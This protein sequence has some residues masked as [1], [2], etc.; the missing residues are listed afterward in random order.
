MIEKIQTPDNKIW[1]KLDHNDKNIVNFKIY[2]SDLNN[3][4]INFINILIF[5]YEIK[6]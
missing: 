6:I 1:V 2:E 5:Y 4:D 3:Y